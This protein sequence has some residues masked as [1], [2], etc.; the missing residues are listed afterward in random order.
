MALTYNGIVVE[1]LNNNGLLGTEALQMN[2]VAIEVLNKNNINTPSLQMCGIVVELK[3]SPYN[4]IQ[5]VIKKSNNAG[6]TGFNDWGYWA[7]CPNN[8]QIKQYFNSDG[9]TY[10]E[11]VA[12]AAA[13]AVITTTN[14]GDILTNYQYNQP[15]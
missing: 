11:L 5:T 9:N 12:I 7:A 14:T 1:Q 4:D 13:E 15:T 2:G 8:T 3:R 6:L 10:A